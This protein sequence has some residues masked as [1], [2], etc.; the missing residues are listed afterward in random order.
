M[1]VSHLPVVEVGVSVKGWWEGCGE[2][3]E[4]TLP[5]H[6]TNIR[7]ESGWQPLHADQEYVLQVSLRRLNAGPR[8]SLPTRTSA[9]PFRFPA[10]PFTCALLVSEEAGQQGTGA[11]LSQAQRRRLVSGSR[12]GGEKRTAGDQAR[13]IHPRPQQRVRGL[14]HA[15]EDGK[16]RAVRWYSRGIF[17]VVTRDL[18]AG[19]STRCT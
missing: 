19:V 10:F 1:F 9:S 4:R 17:S 2:Q 3:T 11:S 8:V 15:G 16:V 14:L 5:T 18:P 7:D 6:V 12:G 13:G